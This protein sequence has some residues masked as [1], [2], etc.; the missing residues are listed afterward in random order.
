MRPYPTYPTYPP[1]LSH[2]RL[3][4][5]DLWV[6]ST[7]GSDRC[8]MQWSFDLE[9]AID[10]AEV[11]EQMSKVMDQGDLAQVKSRDDKGGAARELLLEDGF[12]VQ[13][14]LALIT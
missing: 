7:G 8:I 14:S 4:F 11:D 10:D 13:V 9:T 12:M 1:P 6:I 3:S 5:D 2:Q